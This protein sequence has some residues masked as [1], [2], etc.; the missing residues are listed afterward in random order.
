M[1]RRFLAQ[2]PT[3]GTKNKPRSLSYQQ[4]S[5]YYWWWAYLRRNADYLACCEN[6]GKGKL[7]KLYKN[8]GDVREDNF[9]RWW[10]EE[11]RGGNLFAENKA[12][13]KLTLLEDKSQW[14][15]SW[16]QDRVLI[17]AVPLTSSKRYLQSRFARILKERHTAKRG[18]TKK[19]LEMSNSQYPLER[20][21]TIENLRKTLQVYD[22][23]A[24]TRSASKKVP[25]WKVGENLRLVP[26]AMTSP[27]YMP[28]ENFLR[29][30]VMGATV[31]RYLKYAEKIITGTALG[32]FPVSTKVV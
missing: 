2:H 13:M 26:T 22:E 24:A 20:N 12:A 6:G 4:Q 7:A 29:R 10:T 15:E 27:K 9:K 8:F 21:Y 11:Q 23:Y 5:P 16:T 32:K 28:E 18:R 1:L 30:N 31:K 17:I 3:F 25:L 19:L 14:D